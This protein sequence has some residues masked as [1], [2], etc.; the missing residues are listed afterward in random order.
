V[1]CLYTDGLVE[2]RDQPIDEGIAHLCAAVAAGDPEAGCAAVMA[3]MAGQAPEA[4]TAD[5][6]ATMFCDSAGAH[7]LARAHELAAANG[8]ELRLAL[9]DSPAA[10]IFQLI[11]LDQIVPVYRDVQQSLATSRAAPDSRPDPTA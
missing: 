10:R 3:A 4:I 7:V 9:G 1:L 8:S 11:G 5:M 6:T 2:R